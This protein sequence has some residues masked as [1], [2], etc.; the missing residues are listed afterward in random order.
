MQCRWHVRAGILQ[1][2][3]RWKCQTKW[4]VWDFSLLGLG[5][6][7]LK[8]PSLQKYAQ[9]HRKHQ[10]SLLSLPPVS[11]ASPAPWRAFSRSWAKCPR[12]RG[13]PSPGA[14]DQLAQVR[15]SRGTGELDVPST[16]ETPQVHAYTWRSVTTVNTVVGLGFNVT[17]YNRPLP[18]TNKITRPTLSGAASL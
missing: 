16:P 3:V 11:E 8:S 7:S 6:Q 15:V 4:K 5:Q 1:R 18:Q 14:P 2:P 12:S 10:C 13:E 9:E 17:C